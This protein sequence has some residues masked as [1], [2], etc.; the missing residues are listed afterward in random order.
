ML[1]R[2]ALALLVLFTSTLVARSA[3]ADT[4]STRTWSYLT[5]GNGHG[6]QVFDTS[7]NRITQFLEHPYRYLRPNA[8]D[9]HAEGVGRRDLAYDTY[10]GLKAPGGAGW[11]AESSDVGEAEYVDEA[12]IIRAPATVGGVRAD[13]YFFSPFGIERNV[14]VGV[15]HAPGATDGYALFNFHLGRAGGWDGT[16]PD[17]SG[18]STRTLPGGIVV[19]SGPGGGAMIYVPVGGADSAGCQSV[20]F[21]GKAGQDLSGQATCNADD[22]AVG[23]Q[24]KLDASG[25]MGFAAAF[26]EDAAQADSVAAEIVSWIG[27]RS[28]D[29]LLDDARQE[30]EGWRKPP[31]TGTTLCSEDEKKIWRTSEATLRMGQV[32]EANGAGRM[33][34]GMM[35]ASLPTG[36]W[37]IGWVRDGTYSIVALARSGHLEEARMALDFFMNAEPVGKYLSYVRGPNYRISVTRYFGN[38]EEETDFNGDGPNIEL[39]GWGMVLW[40]ARQY[41]EASGDVDWLASNTRDGSVWDVLT[42]GVA[43]PLESNLETSGIVAA[44]ASIWEVHEAKKKHF[45]FTTLAAARGFCDMA[46]LGKM[47]QRPE[48]ITKY[49]ALEKVVREGFLGKFQDAN[50]ALAG[51]VEELADTSQRRYTD[52]AVAQAFAWNVLRD[53]TGNTAKQTLA[54]L[55]SLKVAS[56]GYKRNDDGLSSYDDNEW[57]FADFA[58]SNAYRRAGSPLKADHIVANVVAKASSNR[59]LLPELYNAVASDG[60]IGVYTGAVPMVGYGAGAYLMAVLDRSGGPLTE[61]SHCGDDAVVTLPPNTCTAILKNLSLR[62]S[63]EAEATDDAPSDVL[64][65]CLCRAGRGR[66][67]LSPASIMALLALPALLLVRRRSR[68]EKR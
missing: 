13:S 63:G 56:G 66:I 8:Q 45:A 17:A 52:V 25:W 14:M 18:E 59:H 47:A 12:G 27:G 40:A 44:D 62:E 60:E 54:L 10:F 61:P 2:I 64:S 16:E 38:G 67:P 26:I 19:E 36:P 20:Y 34:H 15:L 43:V 41:V 3:G 9:P 46:A 24:K 7:T 33:N 48:T 50:G 39:D 23:F 5:I 68:S 32:R 57:V 49:Q 30:W 29:V 37:H 35:L 65:A 21:Q 51:S 11:L 58:M 53:T 1:H 42:T 55:E 28:P 22:I 6:F 31:P 4:P